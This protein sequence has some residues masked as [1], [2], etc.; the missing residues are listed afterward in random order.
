MATAERIRPDTE[1]GA[2][3]ENAPF[4]KVITGLEDVV[5]RLEA[6]D[7]SL[8]DSL[9]AFEEGVRLSRLGSARLDAAEQRV[10]VLLANGTQTPFGEKEPDSR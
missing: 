6:G 4:E 5:A 10:D 1:N 3:E 8:E 2:I 9:C 7:L